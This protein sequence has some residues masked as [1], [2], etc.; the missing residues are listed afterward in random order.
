M[1]LKNLFWKDGEGDEEDK[2]I[3]PVA[4]PIQKPLLRPP[5]QS[6][7]NSPGN[8][9]ATSV[10]SSGTGAVNPK[11]TAMLQ[12]A[13]G[14]A[15]TG[16]YDAFIG[17]YE[18]LKDAIPDEG[19]CFQASFKAA[20]KQNSGLTPEQL[21]TAVQERISILDNKKNAIDA[22]L[23]DELKELSSNKNQ[24]LQQVADQIAGLRTEIAALE[25]EVEKK[26]KSV[27]ELTNSQQVISRE[28][29]NLDNNKKATSEEFARAHAL[30]RDAFMSLSEKIQKY[31][32]EG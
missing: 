8:N 11:F 7:G 14:T 28:L 22:Q 19:K 4:Q 1:K 10:K 13:L 3:T 32:K 27:D 18:T 30:Q 25:I 16:G 23:E 17:L 5:T 26:K 9:S 21:M 12:E 31:L 24:Q 29:S 6:S 20:A 2:K 15:K